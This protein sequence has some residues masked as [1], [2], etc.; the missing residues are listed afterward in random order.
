MSVP[1]RLN[2]LIAFKKSLMAASNISCV[3][4][5]GGV[6][7]VSGNHATVSVMTRGAEVAVVRAIMI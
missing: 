5:S 6:T 3:V 2:F 1:V 4:G 7:S